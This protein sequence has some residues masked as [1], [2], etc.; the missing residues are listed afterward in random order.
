MAFPD[1]VPYEFAMYSAQSIAVRAGKLAKMIDSSQTAMVSHEFAEMFE[2]ID[3]LLEDA[4][5]VAAE[6]NR[7]LPEE[8]EDVTDATEAKEKKKKMRLSKR[9]NVR[10]TKKSLR[11]KGIEY[12]PKYKECNAEIC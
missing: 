7:C 9:G 2:D 10:R 4:M 11:K 6:N 1:D 12:D 3:G 5:K 8:K